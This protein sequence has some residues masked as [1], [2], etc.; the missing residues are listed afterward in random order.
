MIARDDVK[1]RHLERDPNCSLVIFEARVPF[2]GVE[3]RGEAIL[4]DCDVSEIRRSIAKRYLGEDAGERFAA[5]PESTPGVL[6]QLVPG[7]PRLRDLA[8]ILSDRSS[9]D[10][11]IAPRAPGLGDEATSVAGHLLGVRQGSRGVLRRDVT[12][13]HVKSGWRPVPDRSSGLA[14]SWERQRC[15]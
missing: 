13:D 14:N 6:L 11:A 15:R 7:E 5:V 1:L 2:R 12:I 9:R 8:A 4:T 3:V 10:V